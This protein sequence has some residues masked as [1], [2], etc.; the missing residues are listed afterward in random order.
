MTLK[1]HKLIPLTLLTASMSL[2]AAEQATS[3]S[4]NDIMHFETLKQPVLS[5]N[6]RTLAV[7]AMPDRGDSRALINII[8][9]KKQFVIDGGSDVK[10][11]SQGSY[12]IATLKPSLLDKET[13]KKSELNSGLALLNTATGEQQRF[14]KV[15]QAEF[16]D[17]GLFLAIWFDVEDEK[18]ADSDDKDAP[19]INEKDIGSAIKLIKL[20]DN[21]SHDFI[22][23]TQFAFDRVGKNFVVAINDN[24]AKQHFIKK[25]NLANNTLKQLYKSTDNQIGEL[26][27]SD[28][29]NWLA[30]TQGNATDDRDEREY[31]LSLLSL[32]TFELKD[33]PQDDDWTLNQ[34]SKVFFSEDSLRLFLGRVPQVDKIISLAEIETEADLF[35]ETVVTGLRNL[36]VWHGD[37]PKIKPHEIKQYSKEVQRTYLAVLHINANRVVQLADETIPNVLYGEQ[38]RYLLATS[39]VPYQKMIT[40]AGFYQDVYLVDLNTGRKQQLLTQHPTNEMP[41]LSPNARFVAYY[42]Q[43]QLFMYDIAGVRK[44]T[45]SRDISVS[46]ANEDHDYPGNAPSYGFGPWLADGSGIIAYDKYDVWQF[47]TSSFDGYML[48]KGQGRETSTQ[49]R[50]E[51]LYEDQNAPAEVIQEQSV[52]IHGYNESTKA[53]SLYSV[54]IGV[55]GLTELVDSKAKLKVLA[56]SKNADTIVYSKERYDLYP[57]L[58]TA[59]VTSPNDAVKQTDLDK[60]R[61]GFNW[62]SAELVQWSDADGRKT[63]GVLIKPTNYQEGKQY[64][65]MVYFY[66]FMSDRL[67]S[68]PHMAINHRPNFAWYA[69]NGYAIFLPDIR[70]EVGYPGASAVKGLTSGV[71]KLI[72]MGIADPDAVGI[73]GHSWGGYQTA[74]AVTQT[75]IFKAAVTGAPVSNMTSAYSG[76]RHGSGLARQFQYETGQSR[77][78]ESLF[79]S[80]QKYIENSPVF[81]VERIQTPMMIMFG[82]KDDAVPWEQGVELYLAM[83]RTGKD[84]VFLQYE[85]EPHHLK[86]YP[87]KLDYTIRMKQYFDHYLKGAKA[88]EWLEKGEA[89]KEYK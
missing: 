2:T 47:N 63:D 59:S 71:Q 87:N 69:D 68:F 61:D 7:E 15:K 66:R 64:P 23:V 45:I 44:H 65:V 21:S 8:E 40:W 14:E 72:D 86:K 42:Q 78:A 11:N 17:D 46:F 84:V 56:R 57:D 36:K 51:G 16:S 10:V 67:H 35:D 1:L 3:L 13:L 39:D 53:D 81:Y 82:D 54:T 89:Y 43:G 33:T 79:Q 77:I 24:K 76:I 20:A 58:Y 12:A 4:L 88:P 41:T 31:Q 80:P 9:S 5:D 6:G 48:T 19:K 27:L 83:R 75:N 60:Q 50:I 28:D 37:D 29:G 49:L 25:V 70:F 73:Q 32:E 62:G 74:F 30:F 34:Y 55:P 22:N 85:D 18:E 52:L 38:Q 26:S